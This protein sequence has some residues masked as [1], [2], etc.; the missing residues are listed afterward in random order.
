MVN[1]GGNEL[2]NAGSVDVIGQLDEKGLERTI[3]VGLMRSGEKLARQKLNKRIL[4]TLL[5]LGASRLVEHSR[6][7]PSE[8]RG[9]Y[10]QHP[11]DLV[12]ENLRLMHSLACTN[13]LP[14]P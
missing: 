12:D 11:T 1:S 9:G 13:V 7:G 2:A 10:L 3:D 8:S 14:R 6:N 4:S 5:Y